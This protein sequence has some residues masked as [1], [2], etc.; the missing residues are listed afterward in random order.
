MVRR[1]ALSSHHRRAS[2]FGLKGQ[3]DL[4]ASPTAGKGRFPAARP[5]RSGAGFA[6]VRRQWTRLRS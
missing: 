4:L 2:G 6:T 3:G 5:L 1:R